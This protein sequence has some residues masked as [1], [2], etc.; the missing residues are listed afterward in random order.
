MIIN[1][2]MEKEIR[3]IKKLSLKDIFGKENGG[4]TPWL[5]E[6]LDML[7]SAINLP[8][9]VAQTEVTLE[10]LRPDIIAFTDPTD[11]D[12]VI[13][14]NQYDKSDNYHVGKI[15]TYA[16][17]EKRAKY[18]VLITEDA[19]IEHIEAVK[20]M[21][22]ARI[23]GC[24]FF[25]VNASAYQISEKEF[26][27]LF[28]VVVGDNIPNAAQSEKQATLSD[29]WNFFIKKAVEK[30]VSMY[31]R[32]KH[33]EG[34]NL[35]NWLYAYIGKTNAHFVAKVTKT[36]AS[37]YFLFDA[38][39]DKL[40]TQR[41]ETFE[42]NKEAINKKFGSG[43]SWDNNEG[44]VSCKIEYLIDGLGGYEDKKGWEKLA[45]GMLDAIK[46]MNEALSPYYKL[47]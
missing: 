40:N 21:N 22:E 31:A 5:A 24:H 32:L 4:F 17:Y 10:T 44:R 26:T 11:G 39:D 12:E 45:D 8:L 6:H 30:N 20:A 3:E 34:R 9:A 15:L 35:N 14:E 1:K 16:A 42:T 13:I 25:L 46:R 19:R 37:I 23:C 7:S 43:L 41:Y 27:I 36:N 33:G 47:L 38:A 28:N 18:A 29:F 2:E